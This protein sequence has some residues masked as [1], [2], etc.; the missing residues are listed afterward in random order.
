MHWQ[1]GLHGEV[2]AAGLRWRLQ[3]QQTQLAGGLQHVPFAQPVPVLMPQEC[4]RVLLNLI[5]N[6][7]S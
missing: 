3:L 4:R 6:L 7:G 5:S 2:H 1:E